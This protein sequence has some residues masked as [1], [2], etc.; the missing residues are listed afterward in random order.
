MTVHY[1][2]HSGQLIPEYVCQ[3]EGI[4]N[5]QPVCQRVVG[6]DLDRAIGDLLV[7]MVSPLAL[8]VALA[9][10]EELHARAEDADRL[11]RQ[12]VERARYDAELAQ[13]RYLRVDPDNRLVADSL[14]ADWN[15]KLR[16]LGAAQEEYD[17]QRRADGLLLDEQQRGQVLALATDFPRLWHDPATPQRER[18]RMLRLLVEDVTLLKGDELVAAVRFC[19]GATQ[20]L[21]LPRPRNAWQLRQTDPAVVR[22]ID[23]LLDEHSER[24]VVDILNQR[25]LRPGVAAAF[26][27]Y[28][29]WSIR[30]TYGLEDRFARLRRR[31]L[32]TQEEMAR[33]LGV[34]VATVKEWRDVGRLT[35]HRYNDAGGCLYDPPSDPLP[36]THQRRDHQRPETLSLAVRTRGAV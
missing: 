34:C 10:Q 4:E 30:Q 9:V 21:H 5:A 22:E 16:A 15:A 35:A 19:G 2:S 6:R 17:Q 24:E 1:H 12:Q 8:E 14:E 36:T 20:T 3:K 25:G 23:R 11:R 29:V 13:R 18:K 33:L 32:L 28:I 26:S 7:E 31:G 27:R